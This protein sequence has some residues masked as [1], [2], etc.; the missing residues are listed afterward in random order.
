MD[1]LIMHFFPILLL[2]LHPSWIQISR[3]HLILKHIKVRAHFLLRE[4]KFQTHIGKI[5]LNF[6][7]DFEGGSL[8]KGK[9]CVQ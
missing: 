7:E 4:T 8:S 2:I 6:V 1:P 5:I 3:H 9:S